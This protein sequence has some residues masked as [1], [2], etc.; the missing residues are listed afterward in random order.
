MAFSSDALHPL[1]EEGLDWRIG[2]T[3]LSLILGGTVLTSSFG[4]KDSR[5]LTLVLSAVL[6]KDR[7]LRC[8]PGLG[9]HY[10]V[11]ENARHG[12]LKRANV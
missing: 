12:Y 9:C 4:P 1:R 8:G 10:I 5:I 6:A 7:A 11:G 2:G 3:V